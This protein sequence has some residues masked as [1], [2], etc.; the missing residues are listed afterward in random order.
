MEYNSII[1]IILPY[2]K[3]LIAYETIPI[4]ERQIWNESNTL[5]SDV[6]IKLD[7]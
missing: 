3:M 4:F 6:T 1:L 7:S 2:M 5:E